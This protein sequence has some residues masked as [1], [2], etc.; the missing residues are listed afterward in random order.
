MAE[1]RVAMQPDKHTCCTTC[2]EGDSPSKTPARL[3]RGGL[4][5]VNSVAVSNGVY[6]EALACIL[7]RFGVACRLTSL[8]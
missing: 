5:T 7:P 4:N 1:D 8:C 6:A 3:I 2:S